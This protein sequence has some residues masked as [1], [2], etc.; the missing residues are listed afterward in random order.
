MKGLRDLQLEVPG[1]FLMNKIRLVRSKTFD[2][3]TLL[4]LMTLTTELIKDD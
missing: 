3:I 2:P 4:S 1:C